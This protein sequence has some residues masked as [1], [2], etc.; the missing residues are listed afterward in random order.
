MFSYK[1]T[2][3]FFTLFPKNRMSPA[4][5]GGVVPSCRYGFDKYHIPPLDIMV[6]Q[7]T[8]PGVELPFTT[9]TRSYT[10]QGH[11]P[12]FTDLF[13]SH[14]WGTCRSDILFLDQ[15]WKHLDMLGSFDID[16]LLKN[17]TRACLPNATPDPNIIEL[18]NAEPCL[19]RTPMVKVVSRLL[20]SMT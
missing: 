18:V 10:E 2:A 20:E 7:V 8:K 12:F 1:Y 6:Y 15:V 19:Y 13:L 9:V 16:T 17:A 4:N 14:E 3:L 11:T 5:D